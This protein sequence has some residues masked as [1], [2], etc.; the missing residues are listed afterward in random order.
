[1][2]FIALVNEC[3]PQVHQQTISAIVRTESKGNPWAIGINRAKPPASFQSPATKEEAVQQASSLIQQGY[4][5]D[6]G[7]GQINSANLSWLGLTV[8]QAFDPCTNL[9]AAARI[10]TDNYTRASQQYAQEQDSLAA[11]LSA[12]NTGHFERGIT[13]GYV[14]KIYETA[15]KEPP[16]I[17][18]PAPKGAAPAAPPRQQQQRQTTVGDVFD[19]TK[20]PASTTATDTRKLAQ[21]VKL[22]ELLQELQGH[23]ENGQDDEATD[24]NP[25]MVFPSSEQNQ[26][27]HQGREAYVF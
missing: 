22:L 8:E 25:A 19:S 13:N 26:K 27:K 1:M 9:G 7:L 17:K 15:D 3:A 18:V 21:A 20:P 14:H 23:A 12:Y 10:L 16:V 24:L 6:I 4:N 11:A 5:I 2:D